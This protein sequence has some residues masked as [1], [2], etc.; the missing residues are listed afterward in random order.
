MRVVGVLQGRLFIN[1]PFDDSYLPILHAIT[2]AIRFAG[3]IP[4]SALEADDSGIVRLHRLYKI[5]DECKYGI[6][7]MSRIEFVA[8][9]G[10]PRFNMPFECGIFFGAMHYGTRHHRQ[11]RLL[12]LESEQYSTLKTL[13]DISGNDPKAH[14]NNQETAISRV[15]NFLSGQNGNGT[16]PGA[17]YVLALYGGFQAALPSLASELHHSQIGIMKLEHWKLFVIVVEK[18]LERNLPKKP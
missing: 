7:D 10:L 14:N 9:G 4:R 15:L 11:K 3:F 6:H 2:F 18:Y 16:L 5:I 8:P 13:S 12:V 1:C 17:E